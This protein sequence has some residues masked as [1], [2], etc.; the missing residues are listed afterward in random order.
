MPSGLAAP[1]GLAPSQST[2]QGSPL[3]PQ[4]CPLPQ[5]MAAAPTTP[6]LCPAWP[7]SSS[8]A[9]S[10]SGALQDPEYLL[11]QLLSTLSRFLKLRPT[12]S[13]QVTHLHPTP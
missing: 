12:S 7:F 3:P 2:C 6:G 1:E 10:G 8:S 9:L 11:G 5:G 13:I 4:A